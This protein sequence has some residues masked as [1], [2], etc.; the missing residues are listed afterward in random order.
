MSSNGGKKCFSLVKLYYSVF[1]YNHNN[2]SNKRKKLN[3]NISGCGLFFFFFPHILPY[4]LG[5][6]FL[7]QINQ[8]K[9]HFR[10]IYLGPCRGSSPREK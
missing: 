2:G 9:Y 8:Y 7:V 1:S 3:L 5:S 10:K 6:V 4:F